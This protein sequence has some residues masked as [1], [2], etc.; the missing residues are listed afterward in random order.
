MK[1]TLMGY[2]GAGNFGDDLMLYILC[3]ELL[4]QH[5]GLQIDVFINGRNKFPTFIPESERVKV[6]DF[7]YSGS[8]NKMSTLVKYMR[9]RD[10]F[11]WGGGTCFTDKDAIG[12]FDKFT[13]ARLLG[14][15]IAYVGVGVG[16]LTRLQRI[17]K[18][19]ILLGIASTVTLRD[20]TSYTRALE[21]LPF[22]SRR[23]KL[24]LTED[25]TYLYFK[26]HPQTPA[27]P[28]QQPKKILLSWR[29]LDQY[30]PK[31]TQQQLIEHTLQALQQLHKEFGFTQI[32]SLVL[33]NS[34]D[35]EVHSELSAQLQSW[36]PDIPHHH[37]KPVSPFEKID[38]IKGYDA[39]ISVRYHGVLFGDALGVP[40]I[41]VNYSPKVEYYCDTHNSRG[42]MVETDELAQ[43]PQALIKAFHAALQ[44]QPEVSQIS[45]KMAQAQQNISHLLHALG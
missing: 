20:E 31:D 38:L 13:R 6:I 40:S 39:L 36:L 27:S 32:D 21:M 35:N 19:R 7:Q 12:Y 23:D 8:W 37:Y 5:P 14:C 2:Y 3:E 42:R 29:H 11:I 22:N 24:Q 17:I 16:K 44:S 45:E 33:D 18:T 28:V 34:K 26:Q 25:L 15:K 4:A 43:G 30:L 10:A 1:V 9:S 41:A